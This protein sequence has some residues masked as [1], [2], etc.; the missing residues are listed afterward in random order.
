[1]NA[2]MILWQKLL[3]MSWIFIAFLWKK[4][5]LGCPIIFTRIPYHEKY[6]QNV[7]RLR[8][9]TFLLS[10]PNIE[11][12]FRPCPTNVGY[13]TKLDYKL[14]DPG[15]CKLVIR[16]LTECSRAFKKTVRWSERSKITVIISSIGRC[17]IKYQDLD[18]HIW[19]NILGKL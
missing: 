17:R 15:Q 14:R 9:I 16:Q 13:L 3:R 10:S 19:I 5:C 4:N 6:F 7:N 18:L 1:M 2:N 8:C 12:I 11:L